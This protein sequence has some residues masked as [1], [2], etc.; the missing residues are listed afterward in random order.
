MK[1]TSGLA[2]ASLVLGIL[3]LGILAIRNSLFLSFFLVLIL[4]FIIVISFVASVF[5]IFESN[6]LFEKTKSLPFSEYVQIPSYWYQASNY[7]NNV[8]GN[9]R[10]LQTPGDDFYQIPYTWGYYGSDAIAASLITNPVV[11]N[12]VSYLNHLKSTTCFF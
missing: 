7:I 3:V 12:T 1:K 5:P 10:V 11:Q 8:P 9:F 2:V 4:V 6:I